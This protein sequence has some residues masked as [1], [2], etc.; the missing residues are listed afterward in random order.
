MRHNRVFRV[1]SIIATWP[2]SIILSILT[3]QNIYDLLTPVKGSYSMGGV[4]MIV[5]IILCWVGYGIILAYS[6]KLMIFTVTMTI[7]LATG[8]IQNFTLTWG[9]L[10]IVLLALVGFILIV[11][12]LIPALMILA[13]IVAV[14]LTFALS[15]IPV[16]A[17]VFT[18]HEA[19]MTW[20]ICV[21]LCWAAA[22]I[23]INLIEK[24]VNR[25]TGTPNERPATGVRHQGV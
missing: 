23:P 20:L 3:A 8:L 5:S 25:G 14:S 11:K 15:V 9:H 1:F 17:P 2:L 4:I 10:F 16:L 22:S 12:Q 24:L 18:A 13:A 19:A 6:P 21:L 7:P